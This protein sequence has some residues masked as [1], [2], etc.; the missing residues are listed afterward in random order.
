MAAVMRGAPHQPPQFSP[1]LRERAG[2][3][4]PRAAG[5]RWL[6]GCADVTRLHAA[7]RACSFIEMLFLQQQGAASA[8]DVTPQTRVAMVARPP[9]QEYGSC[10]IPVTA[11]AAQERR[12]ISF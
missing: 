8:R 4:M 7:Q 11:I 6:P 12:Q 5:R 1:R 2:Q 9:P 3:Q 10:V